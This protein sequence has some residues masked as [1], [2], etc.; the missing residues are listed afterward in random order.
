M[1][2]Y[3]NIDTISIAFNNAKIDQIAGDIIPLD[4]IF[5]LKRKNFLIDS[6]DNIRQDIIILL[7]Y[8]CH[9]TTEFDRID[10]IVNHH[11]TLYYKNQKGMR[12][13]LHEISQLLITL[14]EFKKEANDQNFVIYIDYNTLF[15]H[16]EFDQYNFDHVS[17]DRKDFPSKMSTRYYGAYTTCHP[18]S[19]SHFP[20][21]PTSDYLSP[22]PYVS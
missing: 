7:T 8:A 16:P 12:R 20:N 21:N 5:D 19:C 13:G 10:N 6:F 3:N 11:M 9:C 2:K 14:K 1:S 18:R 15:Y 17:H 22:T 4:S